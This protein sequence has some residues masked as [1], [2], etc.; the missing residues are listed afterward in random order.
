MSTPSIRAAGRRQFGEGGGGL[1]EMQA[2]VPVEVLKALAVLAGGLDG[3]A[4][5]QPREV[6]DVAAEHGQF[7]G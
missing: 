5:Q 3:A 1:V 7:C 4:A 2:Y 6:V